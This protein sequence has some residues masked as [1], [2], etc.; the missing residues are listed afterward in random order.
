[1]GT[2]LVLLVLLLTVGLVIHTMIKDK[3][4]GKGGCSHGCQNC[5]M[6]GKCHK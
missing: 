2:F 5:A 4:S 3:R 1:M 6:H